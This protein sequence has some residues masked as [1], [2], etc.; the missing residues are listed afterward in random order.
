MSSTNQASS[1][2]P[3]RSDE[4]IPSLGFTASDYRP[5][6]QLCPLPPPE[7]SRTARPVRK[8]RRMTGSTGKVMKEVYFKGIKWTKTFVTRLLDPEHNRH[9]FY[10]QNCKSN[11]SMFSKGAREIA[12]HYQSESH[13]RKDQH[14]RFEQLRSVD[15]VTGQVKHEVRGK[16]GQILTPLE[17]QR[18]KL[19][20]ENAIL[21][22][23]G[24]KHP[25]YDD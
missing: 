6:A 7:G 8:R 12:R 21:V 20:F 1:S 5:L 16:D 4:M 9:K 15:R 22:D 13:L 25:F 11:I 23:I 18:E 2:V 19:L 14:C 10:C 3:V 17:L 24:D